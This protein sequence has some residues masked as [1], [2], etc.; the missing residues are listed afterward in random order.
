VPISRIQAWLR[1]VRQSLV[2]CLT[3]VGIDVPEDLMASRVEGDDELTWPAERLRYHW[4][5]PKVDEEDWRHK[6]MPPEVADPLNA[7][8]P[9]SGPE[10]TWTRR[11][12]AVG[13]RGSVSGRD[14]AAGS[15][16]SAIG[17]SEP[18]GQE[19]TPTIVPKLLDRVSAP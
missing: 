2:T 14:R 4:S 13:G 15:S 17:V 12:C 3:G 1:R 19:I 18:P 7:R 10:T 5:I 6:R 16:H 11:V 9:Q 8:L